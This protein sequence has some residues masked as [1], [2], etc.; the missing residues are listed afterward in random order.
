MVGERGYL[1]NLTKFYTLALLSEGPRHGYE[2]MEELD[3]RLGKKP[4]PGQ[5]YPLLRKLEGGGLI[6][7]RIVKLG[8]RER[9]VYTLT[10]KGRKTASRVMSGFSDVISGILEPKLTKCAHCGCKVYEGGHMERVA[11][12]KLMF[13]CVHCAG[14]YKEH[15]ARA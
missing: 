10:D 14:S 4:S 3:K 1:T 2:L 13:C 11:G 12:E 8:D 7:H 9:K 6:S 5:I 15:L